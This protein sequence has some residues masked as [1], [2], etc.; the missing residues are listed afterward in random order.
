MLFPVWICFSKIKKM[1]G[2]LPEAEG[3]V[4]KGARSTE[5]GSA[6]Q[7]GRGWMCGN[8]ISHAQCA[9]ELVK[10]LLLEYGWLYAF[11]GIY[12]SGH[13][14]VFFYLFSMFYML[15]HSPH[16]FRAL[17]I[18]LLLVEGEAGWLPWA[19]GQPRQVLGYPSYRVTSSNKKK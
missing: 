17:P 11:S 1:F 14:I 4:V 10:D 16:S 9:W 7:H 3:R 18:I 13:F 5:C 12:A 8:P 6:V 15:W 2:G 19:W